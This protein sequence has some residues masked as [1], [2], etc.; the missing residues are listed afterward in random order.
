MNFSM[1]QKDPCM[2]LNT[3]K[4]PQHSS[5]SSSHQQDLLPNQIYQS[6]GSP[7]MLACPHEKAFQCL[8]HIC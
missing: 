7:Q 1:H 2:Q 8:H 4:G 3:E 5:T 6:I